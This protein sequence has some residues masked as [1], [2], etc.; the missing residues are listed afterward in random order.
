MAALAQSTIAW[1]NSSPCDH[2]Q[3]H[4]FLKLATNTAENKFGINSPGPF[5]YHGLSVFSLIVNDNGG[6]VRLKVEKSY[7]PPLLTRD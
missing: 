4:L 3:N 7:F 6:K 1:W 2:L 5:F